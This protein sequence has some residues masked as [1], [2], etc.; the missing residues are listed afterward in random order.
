M[1]LSKLFILFFTLVL[2]VVS[3]AQ[4]RPVIGFG[5]LIV[6]SEE[7]V[8]MI[9][10]ARLLTAQLDIPHSI[11]L[12]EGVFIE[13]KCVENEKVV[14]VIYNDLINIYNNGETAFWEEIS[15]RFDLSKSRQ[16]F[17]NRPTI[18][19]IAWISRRAR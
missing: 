6:S 13:A 16:H 11:Y 4:H 17:V 19:P 14:Y 5:E 12:P 15:S 9:K 3:Y 8:Q 10:D 2:F 18:N 1:K 7:N